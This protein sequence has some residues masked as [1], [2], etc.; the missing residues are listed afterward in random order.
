MVFG[1]YRNFIAQP[2]PRIEYKNL[3]L[4]MKYLE[5]SS[6]ANN[7]KLWKRKTLKDGNIHQKHIAMIPN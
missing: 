4:A 1:G 6:P 7:Q 3:I 2:I 5:Y